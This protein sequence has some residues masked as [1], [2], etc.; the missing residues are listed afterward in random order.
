MWPVRARARLAVGDR[1]S[2]RERQA[3]V[4]ERA[5]KGSA[6]VEQVRLVQCGVT[7]AQES[8]ER[9]ALLPRRRCEQLRLGDEH[10]VDVLGREQQ[11]LRAARPGLAWPGTGR[12]S[13][14]AP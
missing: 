12:S 6:L 7:P 2:E 13:G 4:A 1:L 10:A 5:G 11:Q 9:R 14:P 3:E 8:G